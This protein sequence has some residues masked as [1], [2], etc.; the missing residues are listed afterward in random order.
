M[1]NL[2]H[3]ISLA[4]LCTACLEHLATAQE[5]PSEPLPISLDADSSSFSQET[6]TMVFRGLQISQGSMKIEADE[7]IATGL[8]FEK[9]EWSFNGNVNITIDSAR[10]NSDRAEVRFISHELSAAE[11]EGT[12]AM[13]EDENSMD[14][15]TIRGSAGSL[16]YDNVARTLRMSGSAWLSEG[17]TQFTGCDLIYDLNQRRI[18]SGS[19]DCGEDLQIIFVPPLEETQP[20]PDTAL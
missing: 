17:T 14:E 5:A 11:L 9:S 15:N 3:K 12:P 7:A 4:L 8:D 6:G 2:I 10:I 16:H 13:F 20:E 1:V 19:S 18:T